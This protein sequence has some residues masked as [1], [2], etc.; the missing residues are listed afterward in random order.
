MAS[1]LSSVEDDRPS[2]WGDVNEL[3]DDFI[4]HHTLVGFSSCLQRLQSQFPSWLTRA[5]ALC[6]G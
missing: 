1:G 5:V 3:V 2:W 6:F 4:H